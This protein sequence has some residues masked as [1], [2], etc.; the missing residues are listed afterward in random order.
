MATTG[1]NKSKTTKKTGTKSAP[2]S[3]T[4]QKKATVK[5]TT[6]KKTTSTPSAKQKKTALKKPVVPKTVK[7][8][9]PQTKEEIASQEKTESAEE[10]IKKVGDK[11]SEAADKGVDVLKEVFGKVRDFSF[12][13]AEL[14]R[15]KV[16]I[17]RL[18][19]ERD[20]MLTVMGEKLW[21]MRDSEKLKDLKALFEDDFIKIKTLEN[22]IGKKEKSASKISL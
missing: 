21:E 17:H 13:A 10:K 8:E 14:T 16:D 20:R 6:A 11:L 18:K 3:K 1:S 9:Q 19:S 5:K 4:T 22:E 2:K 15:L 7:K 12:D